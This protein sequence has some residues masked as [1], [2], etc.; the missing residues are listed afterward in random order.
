MFRLALFGLDVLDRLLLGDLFGQ[1]DQI[2]DELDAPYQQEQH[3]EHHRKPQ[4]E[5]LYARP[6]SLARTHSGDAQL[7][8]VRILDIAGGRECKHED[9]RQQR[10]K[11][12]R[13][14]LFHILSVRCL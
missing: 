1:S 6:Q 2:F 14:S 3:D 7:V 8:G 9:D 12:Q 11:Y 13:N 5:H 10:Q 4:D